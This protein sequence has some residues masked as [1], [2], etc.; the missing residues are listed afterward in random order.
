VPIPTRRVIIAI[1]LTFAVFPAFA[2]FDFTGEWAP[3][4]HEDQ[5]ERI[6]GPELGDYLGL[7]INDAARLRAD[8]WDASIQTL[9]EHQCIPHPSTYSFRGPSNLRISREVDPV[10]QDIVSYI[11]YG[12]FGRATRTIWMDGRPHP[13]ASAAHTWAG[14]STGKWEGR[15]LTVETT[16]IKAGYIRRNGVVH[17]DLATMREHFIREGD[18]LTIVTIDEDPVYLT[19]PFIRTTD[20]VLDPTQH[21]GA[22]PCDVTIET[23]RPKGEV[24]HHLPG[25]NAFLDEFP[26]TYHLPPAAA[27]GGAETMYPEYSAK[28]GNPAA[29][30]FA[31]EHA[32]PPAS[33]RIEV[34]PVRGNIYMVAAAGR[35][36]ALSVGPDGVLLVDT[37]LAD[38]ADAIAAEIRKLSS[39]PIRYIIN[40]SADAEHTGGNAALAAMGQRIGGAGP[41]ASGF[42]DVVKEDQRAEI[43]AHENVLNRMSAPTGHA[44]PTPTA[45]WP[46]TT[47][48][49]DTKEFFFND[50]AVQIL[51]QPAAHTDGDSIVFFRRSDVVATGDLFVT[52]GYPLVDLQRGGSIQGVIDALNRILDI[53]IPASQQEGGTMVIPGH[54]RLC[55]EADVVE[56][57]DMVTIIRDRIRDQIQRGLTLE[58]V[59]ASRP[60]RDYDGRYGATTGP[61]TT[62]MF[63]EA[64]Y[65]S[66][67]K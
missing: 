19:E 63:V 40:T 3:R 64:V 29:P 14:F 12:T 60:T 25:A 18:I 37:A 49:I 45:A 23:V 36:V 47:F 53:T 57:R 56:Y 7:P 35:N 55:D 50:E 61:W 62:D 6:P 33:A 38:Q 13:S 67:T 54:G 52:T 58:Q 24:P 26:Q 48:F 22:T 44:P 31:R 9:P 17:S 2:Q 32:G 66:L 46:T 41:G 1:L 42:S 43:F 10:T 65:R 20:F 4:Y 51:H 27:R 5:P 34:L 21:E 11:I 30:S 16:H 8:S 59:K 15:M 28:A 39:K